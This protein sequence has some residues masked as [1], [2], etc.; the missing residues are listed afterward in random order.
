MPRTVVLEDAVLLRLARHPAVVGE[1]P[2]LRPL[3]HLP[4]GCCRKKSPETQ[5][6]KQAF[7][8]LSDERKQRLKA[9]LQADTLRVYLKDFRGVRA[10]VL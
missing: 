4:V 8:T 7:A 5:G 3:A 10:V 9:L 6:I 2:E 1:F